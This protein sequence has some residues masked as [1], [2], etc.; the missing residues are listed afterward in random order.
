M[1]I[2]YPITF[3]LISCFWMLLLSSCETKEKIIPA[4]VIHLQ[5]PDHGFELE[6]NDTLL[7]EPKITYDYNSSYAWYLNDEL[8]STLLNHKH[9]SK[10][11]GKVEYLFIVE[12]PQ[13][14]DSI[15]IPVSTMILL[16]FDDFILERGSYDIGLIM[17]P[18]IE[19]FITKGTVFPR[20]AP[21]E[22]EW[23]GFG[24]SNIY[25]QAT[26]GTISLYSAYA[27]S[28]P[29][30]NFLIYQQAPSPFAS[31]I[32]FENNEERVISSISVANS[33]FAFLIMKYGLGQEIRPFGGEN[34]DLEDW[35]ILTIEGYDKKG[36]KTG[37]IEFYLADYT[38]ENRK[39]NYIIND[40]TTIQLDSLKEVNRLVLTLTSSVT[41]NQGIMLTPPFLC[42]DNI[43]IVK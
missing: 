23:R 32:Y 42:I 14:R 3:L 17:P 5:M 30:N 19:G 1:K 28:T 25:S 35:F 24:L 11:L 13:G 27:T 22:E 7:I 33:T 43:K 38:F 21:S 41:N 6:V 37:E 12:N 16:N 26:T 18:E 9:I 2:N 31:S 40:W 15:N 4:P 39:R 34:N 29:T 36:K 8:I 20:N 10:E